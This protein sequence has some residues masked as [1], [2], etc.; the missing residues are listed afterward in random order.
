M[1]VMRGW[2]RPA[3][4]NS[5]RFNKI[6]RRCG[7]VIPL[8]RPIHPKSDRLLAEPIDRHGLDAISQMVPLPDGAISCVT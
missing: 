2:P 6:L 7:A 4:G 1:P 3:Q 8:S 5:E